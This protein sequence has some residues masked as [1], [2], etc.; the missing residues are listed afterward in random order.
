MFHTQGAMKYLS[1]GEA[2]TKRQQ[3]IDFLYRIGQDDD[4]ERFE[5]MTPEEYAEHKG[6]EIIENPGSYRRHNHMA[7]SSKTKDQL[8]AELDEANDYIEE[9][10]SKLDDIAGIAAD[11]DEADDVDD[12][13]DTDADD[14]DQD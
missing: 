11:E 9:L 8:Q 3:A 7:T 1:V 14:L 13:D 12:D 10:E 5:E 6:A 2:E 4:A